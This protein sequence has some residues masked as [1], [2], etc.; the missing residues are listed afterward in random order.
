MANKLLGVW[1]PFRREVEA[2]RMRQ[3]PS[4][5]R[6][7]L[8]A[9]VYD[10]HSSLLSQSAAEDS[11]S[12]DDDLYETDVDD[13]NGDSVAGERDRVVGEGTVEDILNDGEA[14]ETRSLVV[15]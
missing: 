10:S 12:T 4:I 8:V 15:T 9:R 14:E 1:V 11:D 7:T 2:K 5:V 13:V 6:R 3:Q